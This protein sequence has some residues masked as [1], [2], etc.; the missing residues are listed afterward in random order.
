ML[1]ALLLV[2]L[3]SML[4]IVVD[5]GMGSLRRR[6]LQSAADAAA[7]AGAHFLPE[8]PDQARALVLDYCQRNGVADT[9]VA[10]SF[11]VNPPTRMVVRINRDS[12]ALFSKVISDDAIPLQAESEVG[13]GAI[14]ELSH[15]SPVGVPTGNFNY[16]ELYTLK[17]GANGCIGVPGNC[18]RFAPLALGGS[19]SNN[20]RN[21]L[22]F[23]YDGALLI[24]DTVPKERDN[25]DN[26]TR[27]AIKFRVD[28]RPDETF[29]TF[30]PGS[31]RLLFV[32]LAS[33]V[34]TRGRNV[35]ITGFTAFF[36][37]NYSLTGEITGRFL[38]YQTT[39][40]VDFNV[41]DYSLKGA[42]LIR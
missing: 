25:V 16:G 36:I 10:V 21:V 34:D 24:G 28:Q 41:T 33:G 35:R 12:E 8:N 39:G 18:S 32:A 6:N 31:P 37:E 30:A 22:K 42:K 40:N 4:A 15:S 13:V 9:E 19:G 23:G 27:Q 5:V 14:S 29:A 1:T 26:A 11:P 2:A 17:R 38:K 7:L 3:L 20:Y